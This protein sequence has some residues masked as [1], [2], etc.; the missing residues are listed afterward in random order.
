MTRI[1][2]WNL[3]SERRKL[4][5]LARAAGLAPLA[6]AL[7]EKKTSALRKAH[8]IF[9]ARSWGYKARTRAR[10]AFVWRVS[11]TRPGPQKPGG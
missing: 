2:E 7:E 6:V 5:P 8:L 1:P 10:S 9:M 4:V 3:A 11:G